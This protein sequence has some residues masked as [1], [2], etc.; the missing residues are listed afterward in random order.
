MDFDGAL[1]NQRLVFDEFEFVFETK[2]A[3][4]KRWGKENARHQLNILV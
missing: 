3:C 4:W 2:D 1:C